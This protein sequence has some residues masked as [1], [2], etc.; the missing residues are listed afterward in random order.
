ME[1]VVHY[2]FTK[3]EIH[4]MRLA[5][6]DYVKNYGDFNLP[7]DADFLILSLRTHD[8]EKD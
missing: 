5:V 1:Q 8:D 2:G 7:T 4:L 3:K 6:E